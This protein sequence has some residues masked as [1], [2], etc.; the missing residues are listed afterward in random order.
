MPASKKQT[1]KVDWLRQMREKEFDDVNG[2]RNATGSNARQ[3]GRKS[4]KNKAKRR[5][6][7]GS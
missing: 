5:S 1:G 4:D 3:S 7:D 6:T 2:L